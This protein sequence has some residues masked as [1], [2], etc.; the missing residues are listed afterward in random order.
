MQK[1]QTTFKVFHL[2]ERTSVHTTYEEF[3]VNEHDVKAIFTKVNVKSFN[4]QDS[5]SMKLLRVYA[6]ED[7]QFFL[8]CSSCTE[9]CSNLLFA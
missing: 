6:S 2:V 7:C 3:I 1:K 8:S 9:N 4:G 5:V